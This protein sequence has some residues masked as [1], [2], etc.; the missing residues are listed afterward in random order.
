MQAASITEEQESTLR[1]WATIV[2]NR[3]RKKDKAFLQAETGLGKNQVEEWFKNNADIDEP[4][5]LF[6]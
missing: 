6:S 3:P 5:S 2:G 1:R 4:K